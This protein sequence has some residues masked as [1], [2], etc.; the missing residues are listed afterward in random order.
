MGQINERLFCKSSYKF[1][2][3]ILSDYLDQTLY[4]NT[5]NDGAWVLE[6]EVFFDD[7]LPL[8]EHSESAIKMLYPMIDTELL[9]KQLWAWDEYTGPFIDDYYV[10][11]NDL[12]VS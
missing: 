7:F 5:E 9:R 1:V 11:D 8:T 4:F 3:F 2:S 6:D 12:W 10:I